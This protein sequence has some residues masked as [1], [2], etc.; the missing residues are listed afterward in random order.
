MNFFKNQKTMTKILTGFF[1]V[2]ALL[3]WV[4]VT[5]LLHMATIQDN[6]KHSNSDQFLPLAHL[7]TTPALFLKVRIAA[8]QSVLTANNDDRVRLTS[9]I[10]ELEPPIDK[11][12]EEYE[13]SSLSTTEKEDLGK[14]KTAF[15]D[16]KGALGR[17]LEA[18][19]RGDTQG[20][21]KISLNECAPRSASFSDAVDSLIKSKLDDASASVQHGEQEYRSARSTTIISLALGIGLAILLGVAIARMIAKPLAMSVQVL[22]AVADGDL[23]QKLDHPYHDEV[24]LMATALN[25]ALANMQNAIQEIAQSSQT[26]AGSAEELTA[27]SNTMGA[28]AEETSAQ[29]GVVSAAAEQVTS[30]LHTVATATEEMTASIKEI[31]QNASQAAG[32]AGAAVKTAED[33]N[34]RV[35]K[36]GQSSAEIGQ[37]I[38][39]ITSIAQQT[40]LLALNATIEAARA[41]EAGK[42]FA[43]VAHEVKELAEETAK[44]TK[45]ISQKINAIQDDS[46]GAVEAI[47]EI[48]HV[49]TR[50]SDISNT[51]ASAVEEQTA[52]TNE[53]ARSV[54]E[55]AQGAQQVAE[56]IT[57]VATVAKDTSSGASGAHSASSELARI[58]ADLQALA[59]RFKF[60]TD[61]VGTKASTQVQIKKA[62]S[63]HGLWKTKFQDFM[64]DKLDLDPEKV[65]LPNSCEFGKWLERDGEQALGSSTFSEINTLHAQFHR[66]AA[67]VV[68]KKKSG[69]VQGAEASL[70]ARGD[71]GQT[72][73]TLILKLNNL[74][75]SDAPSQS[76]LA[77]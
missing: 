33:A 56:N 46:R 20:A 52:T 37:V 24:G 35:A 63:V 54:A 61:A 32:V 34:A 3:F 70:G 26:L 64:Q 29:A 10:K 13:G 60:E 55:A 1:A 75:R 42:G 7:A 12:I 18:G 5:G 53:M 69:D 76:G 62:I 15:V 31:A 66:V 77:A 16:Y 50:I 28:N 30:N 17:F 57:A 4:G 39:V 44:A 21:A 8:L 11:A 9:Q 14:L 36:L 6:L 59:G 23:T 49:I 22:D 72:S 27:V 19:A 74:N 47:A 73:T 25:K 2:A 38:K 68:R 58:A 65:K 67:A 43:V 71:F 48:S 51:I 41:G 40:N 45:D